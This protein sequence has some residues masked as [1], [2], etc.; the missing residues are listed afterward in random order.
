[1]SKSRQKQAARGSEQQAHREPTRRRNDS[2]RVSVHENSM[3]LPFVTARLT[4]TLNGKR[5]EYKLRTR[6]I[7]V[8]KLYRFRKNS[9]V[10]DLAEWWQSTFGWIFAR[11][12]QRKN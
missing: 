6:Q 5:A 11:E 7:W 3:F 9:E 2:A 10:F 12:R 8:R 1:M 4:T